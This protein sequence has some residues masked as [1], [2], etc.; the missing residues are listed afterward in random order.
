M[1][2]LYMRN[3]EVIAGPRKFTSDQFN[4]NFDV[5]FDDGADVNV[6]D[7]EI[8]NLSGSTIA[9]I[10]GK[11]N[12]IVNAGYQNDIGAVFKGTAQIIQTD[13]SGVDKITNIMAIDANDDWMNKEIDITFKEGSTGYQVI[14]KLWPL[15]GI[16]LKT[17]NL[18]LNMVYTGGKT[19]QGKIGKAII[20]VATDCNAKVHV[21]KGLLYI[22]PKAEGDTIAFLLDKEHGLIGS[23]TPIEQEEKYNVPENVKQSDG[24]YKW[25]YVKKSSIRKGYKITSLL[26]SNFTTDTVLKVASKTANGLFRIEKGKH[27][28]NGSSFYTEMEVYPV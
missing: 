20:E 10:Q 22:R 28:C 23:P 1:S 3:V 26:N 4:I 18:P 9:A 8:Y 27:T 5:P 14:D 21:N 17:C 11:Y 2:Q 16:L 15:T 24:K 6:A 13:W 19:I 7:I 12:I 25:E